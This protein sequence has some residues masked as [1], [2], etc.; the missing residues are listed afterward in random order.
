MSLTPRALLL[1]PSFIHAPSAKA[2]PRAPLG[3]SARRP[4]AAP[5]LGHVTLV[6]AGPGDPDLLTIRAARALGRA[7]LVLLDALVD[8]AVL[9]YCRPEV[10]VVEVGKQGFKKSTA[11]SEINRLMLREARAGSRLV[12]LK[13]GD[14]FVF[15][16]GGEEL[17]FLSQRNIPCSV[18]PGLSSALSLATLAQIPLTHRGVAQHFS[19]LSGT[20]VDS[21]TELEASWR[22]AAAGGGTLVFLMAMHCLERLVEVVISGGRDAQ[23]PAAIIHRGASKQQRVLRA[24]LSQ[25][26]SVARRCGLGAPGVIIVGEAVAALAGERANVG[27][28]AGLAGMMEETINVSL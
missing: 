27:A 21:A 19:V 7:D 6:G 20:S 14:P 2:S 23:T 12:R 13:G 1:L 28:E 11:Q 3:A 10:R 25:L 18:I 24:P 8:R 16:R 4:I 17:L 26:P 15:G 5:R 9:D 22:H